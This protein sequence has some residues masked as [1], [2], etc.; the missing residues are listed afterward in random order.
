MKIKTGIDIIEVD[1]IKKNIEKYGEK[2]LNKVYTKNEIEY[3]E[4]KNIQRF[5]SYSA[6]FA[7]K[8]AIFKAVSECLN[9]KF[10]IIKWTD[11]EVLNDKNGRPY[12]N[13]HYDLH[14]CIYENMEIDE[15]VDIDI[16]LSHIK[17]CAIASVIVYVV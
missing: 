8:E 16:S 17:N 10:Q 14:K 5:E 4:S 15:N 6:R 11:I 9:N 13:L 3:C 2:F 1:R 7:A 12:V